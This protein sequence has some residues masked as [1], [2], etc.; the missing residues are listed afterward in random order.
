MRRQII[1]LLAVAALMATA[2][3]ASADSPLDWSKETN[4][5]A[6]D[7]R[8][9]PVVNINQRVT[10]DID[11]GF[12]GGWAVNT[13]MRTI[14]LWEIADGTYCAVVRYSG[15][16]DAMA[17]AV[18]PGEG[19]DSVL[20]GNE[21][22]NFVGGYRA[23]IEG[24]L[25][26]DSA[27]TDRGTVGHFDYECVGLGDCPGAV[28]WVD[29]YFDEDYDFTYEFWGWIYRAGRHGT[30]VNAKTGSSGDIG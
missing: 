5:S 12:N 18:S 22:G 24:T 29:Q 26:S 3:P 13:Y 6:C 1:T 4:R 28:N 19:S 21:D 16:F 11:S 2:L 15:T 30:W 23:I 17:G 8:G 14:Q 7:A 9:A 10:G 20:D 25:V 27:W